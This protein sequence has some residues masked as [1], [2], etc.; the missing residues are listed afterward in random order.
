VSIGVICVVFSHR[1]CFDCTSFRMT[2]T[3][4]SL[5]G[6]NFYILTFFEKK[7]LLAFDMCLGGVVC[8]SKDPNRFDFTSFT[9]YR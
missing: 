7:T 8:V 6:I 3:Y 2:T 1:N 9:M 5:Q 4:F